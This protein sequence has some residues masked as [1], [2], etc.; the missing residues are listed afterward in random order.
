MTQQSCNT[1][2]LMNMEDKDMNEQV[3]CVCFNL[4]FE[5]KGKLLGAGR[6]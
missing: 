6:F 5:H 3:I 2:N 4:N 1:H